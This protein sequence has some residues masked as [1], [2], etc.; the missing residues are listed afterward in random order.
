MQQ[1]RALLTLHF[2][3][4]SYLGFFLKFSAKTVLFPVGHIFDKVNRGIVQK[5]DEVGT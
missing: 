3:N 5:A 1:K 4:I 2:R